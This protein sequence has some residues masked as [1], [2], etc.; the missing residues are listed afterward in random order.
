MAI[1]STPVNFIAQTGN[2]QNFLSWD[3]SAGATTYT[4]QRS[5]DGVSFS[6]LATPAVNNYLDEAV[7]IGTEYWYQVASTNGDGTSPYTEAQSLVP[8]TTGEMSLGQIRICAQQRADRVNSDFVSTSE[9]N[10]YI[11]Q[12]MFEL[13]DLLITV[14]EDYYFAQ[15]ATFNTNGST[16][17]YPLPNGVLTF[18]DQNGSDFV[19]R[20][21]YK[22]AGVDLAVNNAQNGYVTVN[23]FNFIDRNKFVYPNTSS[24]IYGVF[25]LRYRVLGDKIELIPTPAANQQIRLW[26]IPRLQQLL[27]DT[28]VTDVGISGWLEYVIVK[29]AYL[30]L[31][32][33]ESD[34]SNLEKQLIALDQRIQA[35]AANRDAGQPDSIS[36]VRQ[37]QWNDGMSNWNNGRGG[38]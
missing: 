38:W 30:A 17:L 11:N 37:G 29:A 33:E 5:T 28:D 24:T 27:K 4:L 22:L 15:P 26:Y 34:T 18:Q 14:Y 2:A 1:P 25:N 19:P 21:F 16:F 35:S 23:K 8:T 13:Y 6:T 12:C 32:K 7:T 36:D 3:R 20:P 9:W 31:C 10:S